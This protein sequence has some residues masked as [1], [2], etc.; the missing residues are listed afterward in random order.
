MI[1]GIEQSTD[2]RNKQTVIK[3][4]TSITAANKWASISGGFTHKDPK[5]AKNYHHTYRRL[6][7]LSGR[8]DR[9]AEEFKERGTSTY[10]LNDEDRLANYVYRYG[11]PIV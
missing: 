9:K 4:F 1:Y 7:K 8:I 11:E 2:L 6:F 3:K 5:E 10:P